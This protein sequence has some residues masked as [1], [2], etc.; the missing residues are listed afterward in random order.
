MLETEFV[1]DVKSTIQALDYDITVRNTYINTRDRAIY[2]DGL[3]EGLEFPDGHDKTLY[4]WPARVVDIHAGQVM[5]R[6]FTVFSTYDKEDPDATEDQEQQKLIN[7]RNKRRKADADARKRAIDAI[8]KDN[9]G[10]AIFHLGAKIGSGFGQT[11]IKEWF[12]KKENKST[13]KILEN[14]QN[15]RPGWNGDDFRARD[16][17]A[18]VYQISFDS[19]TRSFGNLEFEW[20]K[21]GQ[22]LSGINDT[23]D[24]LNQKDAS[25]TDMP[26]QSDRAMV[27]VIDITGYIPGWAADGKNDYK[28]VKR[29]EETKLSCLIVGGKVVQVITEESLMPDF[30]I[31]PNKIEPRRANGASD[32]NDSA[33]SIARTFIEV[34]STAISLY[35]KEI[36]PTYKAKGFLAGGIP[37]RR[38]KEATMI[39]MTQEQDI[40]LIPGRNG[41]SAETDSIINALKEEFVRVTSVGRVMF[42]DP[43]INANSNQALMTTLKGLID[44]TEEKQAR[45]EA[46]LVKMFKRALQKAAKHISELK[47]VVDTEESW[48]LYIEWPSV[49]RKEDATYQQMWNNIWNSSV[50]SP[51]SYLQKLGFEDPGEELD[52]IRDSLKDPV[53]AAMMGRAVPVLAQQLISP[54]QPQGPQVKYNVNV[55]ADAAPDANPEENSAIISEVMGAAQYPQM[56]TPQA[57]ATPDQP[58]PQLTTDQNTGQV[59]SQPGSG[60]PAVSPEGAIA[61]ANQNAGV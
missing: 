11:V 25:G 21:Q 9:G 51:E 23:S 7:L 15:Y 45:W 47:E 33:L 3:F 2:G 53:L 61:Q 42:D 10:K 26:T 50:I 49:L 20:T 30:Y 40:D 36:A 31:I 52:R 27:T 46:E 37:P 39:P 19:A 1:A 43:T 57:P 14:V 5:G 55:A 34:M 29:G 54:P 32:L 44:V 6:G 24:P 48:D 56:A 4:N 17:D 8:I 60:A 35:H 28:K 38:K 13:I 58:G 22:P 59:A 18:F 16:W 41:V 12:D